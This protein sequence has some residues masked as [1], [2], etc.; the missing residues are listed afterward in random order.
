[1]AFFCIFSFAFYLQYALKQWVNTPLSKHRWFS[2]I[3]QEALNGEFAVSIYTFFFSLK[4]IITFY[5]LTLVSHMK[6]VWPFFVEI[7]IGSDHS[8]VNP[9]HAKFISLFHGPLSLLGISKLKLD[10][11]QPAV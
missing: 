11:G 6:H 5:L 1:M 8:K 10:I 4:Q 7:E 9:Y 3:Q 2:E